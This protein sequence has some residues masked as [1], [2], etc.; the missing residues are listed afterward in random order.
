MT[1][2]T[3]DPSLRSWLD[4]ANDPAGDFPIQ[5]LPYGIFTRAAGPTRVKRVGVAIGDC[6]L[7]LAEAWP[8]LCPDRPELAAWCFEQPSL[9]ALLAQNRR[10]WTLVRHR[11]CRWLLHSSP[12]LRDNAD[13]RRRALLPMIEVVLH[14]PIDAGD[15]TDFYSSKE[16]ATNVGSM[17]RDP[18]NA[19][20]PN[21]KHIPIGY[22]GRSSSLVLSG[23]N[24]R[25]PWGQTNPDD[26]STP[27][28]GPCRLLDFELEVGFVTGG[29]G[30]RLGE[31]IPASRA[32]EHIYGML[33]VND[34]S[35]RDIQKWEYQPLGPFTA[36]NFATSLSPWLVP[37]EALEPYRVRTPREPGDPPVQSYLD[38]AWDWNFD[39]NLEVRLQSAQMRE[40]GLSPQTISRVNFGLMYW[41][42]C[43]QLAQQTITGC[44]VRPGD[45]YASGTVTGTT[46]DS[47]GSMLEITWRGTQ[48]LAL[49]TGEQRKFLADGDAV[50]MTGWCQHIGFPRIGFGHV[51]GTVLPAI[52]LKT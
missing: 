35:A 30:N 9:N 40:K 46:P 5:N 27:V 33:L 21:W 45:L 38:G 42:M 6:V 8:E 23:T 25:R 20:L 39:L 50:L 44:N 14:L 11:L 26:S 36:K 41:N 7:D 24:V 47:R 48:P 1:D 28:F 32:R 37:I 15:Y 13:L 43:Q 22:H 17:F 2:Q 29:P 34:W 12:E 19:L 52:E 16:H 4:S 51:Q 3:T 18:N 49:P 31:P 10:T